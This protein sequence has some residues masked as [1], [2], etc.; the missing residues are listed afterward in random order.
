MDRRSRGRRML[1]PWV[2]VARA[3]RR[4]WGGLLRL[5][6]FFGDLR[7]FRSL[8]GV[9]QPHD[10]MPQ[11]T[12]DTPTHELDHHYFFQAAW[13]T[14][15]IANRRPERHVD[16]GSDTTF[17]ACLTA[18]TGV[19]FVDVRPLPAALDG[20]EPTTGS[21]TDLPFEDRSVSSLSSLHVLE[22]VGLGRYGDQLDP[23][24]TERA[25]RELER[26]LATGGEL[27]VSMPVGVPR[28]EFNAH[29]VHDPTAVSPFFAELQLVE[30]S[31]V[32]DDGRLLLE[33][34]PAQ[35]TDQRYACGLY[36]FRRAG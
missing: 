2:R 12:D 16:V 34:D 33:V 21:V 15:R 17:V 4:S 1:V 8:G 3:L 7:R 32:T 31:I 30:F 24:G 9:A 11:L 14:R 22:H 5:P 10:W 26:V 6:R 28:T 27:Y 20:L 25:C 35:W 29:R 23:R 19:T 36:R 13:A 18:L